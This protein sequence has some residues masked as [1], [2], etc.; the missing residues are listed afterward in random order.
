ML[1]LGMETSP[2]AVHIKRVAHILTRPRQ[3]GFAQMKLAQTK[4]AQMKL[5]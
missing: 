3:I 4:L 5:A 1:A 2:K